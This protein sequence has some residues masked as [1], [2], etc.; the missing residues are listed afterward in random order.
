MMTTELDFFFLQIVV[1]VLNNH[2]FPLTFADVH[3][4]PKTF[5]SLLNN[6]GG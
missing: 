3:L 6:H 4:L 2:V 5:P 1:E